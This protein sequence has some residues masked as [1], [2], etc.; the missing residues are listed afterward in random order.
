MYPRN[1]PAPPPRTKLLKNLLPSVVAVVFVSGALSSVA[2]ADGPPL[3]NGGIGNQTLV[4]NQA[5]AKAQAVGVITTFMTKGAQE[6]D[7]K[8]KNCHSA[9]GQDDNLDY[10]GMQAKAQATTGIQSFNFVD[11]DGGSTS[12]SAQVSS[13]ALACGDS[14]IKTVAGIAFKATN[15]AVNASGEAQLTFQ[16]CTAPSRG[17][18]ITPPSNAMT[19]S[20]D[21]TQSNFKPK[22]GMVCAKA[23]CDTEPEGSL[24]GWSASATI[25]W[26]PT[27][28]ANASDSDKTNNGLGLVF[29]PPLTGGV[30]ANFKADSDNMTAVKI[31]ESFVN[32]QTKKTAMGLRIAYRHKATVTKDMLQNPASVTNPGDYTAHWDTLLKL[33][34]NAL[35]PKYGQKYAKNGSECLQQ[36]QNGIEKDGKITVCDETYT[37]ESGIKPIA[38]TAQVAAQGQ[39]CG[40]TEQCLQE[41]VNTNTW[42]Q[43]CKSDVPLSLRNCETTTAYTSETVT[44]ART[45][46]VETCR[47]KRTET[48]Q[49]CATQALL[50]GVAP[51]S[52]PAGTRLVNNASYLGPYWDPYAL[53]R[54]TCEANNGLHIQWASS[55]SGTEFD[56]AQLYGSTWMA[57][58]THITLNAFQTSDWTPAGLVCLPQYANGVTNLFKV[59]CTGSTC[60]YDMLAPPG[61]GCPW[62]TI[63]PTTSGSADISYEGIITTLNNCASYE[64]AQ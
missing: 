32:S 44:A 38:K 1:L 27:L 39:D 55:V 10:V 48:V 20:T 52:C 4:D 59:S 19:C 18:P 45:R 62:S 14:R 31:V 24:N 26:T 35:I 43:P 46:S 25:S 28:P 6:C 60:T 29:Y 21:M 9:F 37:N 7:D 50:T 58:D 47:E 57:V 61:G 3:S 17:L 2:L 34:G 40:T 56:N 30:P 16:V 12:I 64:A 5:I 49:S 15:C 23:S 22:A 13:L 41:V 51:S 42:T 8:G 53:L 36:I 54:V 11:K 63:G 33:Q